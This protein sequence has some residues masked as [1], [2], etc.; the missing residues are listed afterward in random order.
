MRTWSAV[1]AA[2][3]ELAAAVQGRFDAHGLALLATLRRDGSPRLSGIEPL[4]ALDHVWLGMMDGSRKARDLRRD[5][6]LAL[7]SATVDKQV[8][9]GDA[10]LAGRAELV[11]DAADVD[12]FL[13]EFHARTGF[14]APGPL[15]LFQLDVTEISLIRPGDNVLVIEWWNPEAG[16]QRLERA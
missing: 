11:E 12:A 1:L 6:R 9:E 14:D 4:F 7:H 15:H 13:Q 3:P 10:R 2:A 5:P 16:V 8:T